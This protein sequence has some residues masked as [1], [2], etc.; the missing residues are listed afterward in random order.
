MRA[1]P[2][3][4][5]CGSM[6]ICSSPQLFA[7]CRVLLRRLMPRHPPYALISLIVLSTFFRTF[8]SLPLVSPR[9]T[10]PTSNFAFGLFFPR[11]TRLQYLFRCFP[12]FSFASRLPLFPASAAPLFLYSC[13][14]P[15]YFRLSSF[16]CSCQCAYM[17]QRIG[18]R[19]HLR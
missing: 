7:A 12:E 16:L 4:D 19:R 13:F 17:P 11:I 6:L 8:F 9:G 1:F 14:S 5:I 15:F 2:H 3:S 10:R 18:C